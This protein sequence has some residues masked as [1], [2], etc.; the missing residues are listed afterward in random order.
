MTTRITIDIPK[1]I[2]RKIDTSK[3]FP[4]WN[5]ISNLLIEGGFAAGKTTLIKE[6]VGNIIFDY[7]PFPKENLIICDFSAIGEFDQFEDAATIIKD[8][9]LVV[10]TL[11][12]MVPTNQESPKFCIIDNLDDL[13][14]YRPGNKIINAIRTIKL[15]L[16]SVHIIASA[17]PFN[18]NIIPSEEVYSYFPTKIQLFDKVEPMDLPI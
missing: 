8:E 13:I 16:P 2:Q 6:L 15:H 4:N 14:L 17:M 10:N 5:R 12:V 1:T 9:E 11:E 18:P 7:S 3:T